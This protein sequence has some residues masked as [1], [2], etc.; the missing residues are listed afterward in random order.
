MDLTRQQLEA[1]VDRAFPGVRLAESRALA[2][3]RYALALPDGE[4]LAV[5]VYATSAA[6]ERATAALRLLRAEVDLPIPQLRAS[7]PQGQTVGQPYVLLSELTGEPLERALPRIDEEQLYSIGRRLGEVLCRVHRLACERYGALAGD[8]AATTGDEYR[9]GQAR[10]EHEL[11]QCRDLGILDRRSIAELRAWF[12]QEFTPVGRQPALICG[13]ITPATILVRQS[14]GRWWVSGLLGWEHALGWSPAWEHVTFFEAADGPRY[15]GL[16]VGYGNG[17]D[18]QT[19]RAYEQVREHAIAPYRALL[20]LQRMREAFA[21]GDIALG[22]RRRELLKGLLRA[23]A[24]EP[25]IED[26]R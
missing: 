9:Y 10:L 12:K 17:Y 18:E 21:E 25:K 26:R 8:D 4:R 16:R 20:V 13:G 6:V 14:E 24:H 19:T 1:I 22:E 3:G 23:G 5:W 15:F 7:D 11:A 2:T